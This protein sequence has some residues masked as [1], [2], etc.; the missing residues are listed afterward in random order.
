MEQYGKLAFIRSD[1]GPEF[2][3]ERVQTWAREMQIAWRFN[4]SYRTEVLDVYCFT[5]LDEVR[6]ITW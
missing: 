6:E 2:R 3:S 4:R 5:S 1:N